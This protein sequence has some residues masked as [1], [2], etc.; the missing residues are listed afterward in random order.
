M[1]K[2][3]LIPEHFQVHLLPKEAGALRSILV[4]V[5]GESREVFGLNEYEEEVIAS[6]I[7]VLSEDK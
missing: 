5:K 3:G 4:D 6:V 2:G 7:D 1:A